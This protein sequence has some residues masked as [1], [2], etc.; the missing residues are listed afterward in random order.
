MG[1][2]PRFSDDENVSYLATAPPDNKENYG[3]DYCIG[4]VHWTGECT[5]PPN[6][7][8]HPEDY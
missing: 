3:A 8:C 4:C 1:M 2:I 6:G 5:C 7:I